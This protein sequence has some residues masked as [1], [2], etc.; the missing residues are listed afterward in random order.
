M[1]SFGIQAYACH[2]LTARD[3]VI[4]TLSFGARTRTSFNKEDL[5]LMK[6]VADHVAIAME[7]K[8]AEEKL[9]R[10]HTELDARVRERTEQLASTVTALQGEIAIREQAE[11]NLQRLNSLYEVL[12]ETDKAI[13]RANDRDTL[14]R[15]FCRIAVEKGGFILCWVGIVERENGQVRSVAASGVTE[16]LK[17]IR[18]TVNEEPAGYGPTGIAIREGR[19]FVCNDFETDSCTVP[20]HEEGE[21]LGIKASASIALWEEGRVIGA[22]TVYAGEENFFDQAHEKLLIQMGAD[23]S[24]ALDNLARETRRKKTEQALLD[25]TLERMVAV[26]A[27]REKEQLLLQQNRFAT[28]GEMIRNIAHQWRQPLKVLGLMLQ[29]IPVMY[30]MGSFN[31]EYLGESI[32]KGMDLI[33]HMSQTIDDFRNF[34][35]PDKEKVAFSIR[36]VVEKNLA[37]IGGGLK[38]QQIVISLQAEVDPVRVGF[39]NE[40][41]QAMLNILMNARD[42]IRDR[43]VNAGIITICIFQ[44]GGKAVVTVGDNAGGVPEEIMGKIFDPYFSTKGPD[45][46]TGVGLFMAKTIIEQNMN[47]RLTVHNTAEGAEFRIEL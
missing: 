29:E 7:R 28:M 8:Q 11:K 30:D 5:A 32:N 41:S 15:D 45:K 2:P 27:L 18:V 33:N 47:G 12:N 21:K 4:G 31:R 16:Y 1:K 14:F 26:E 40:F 10:A 3:R 20:W 36:E 17:D 46:G 38:N 19:L 6:T 39:P 25:E 24:F 13:I 35:L 22:L 37:L 43:N 23:I 9:R 42:A 34:F 44:E